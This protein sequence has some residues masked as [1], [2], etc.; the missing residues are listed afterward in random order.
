MQGLGT[1]SIFTKLKEK[2]KKKKEKTLAVLSF[3][4]INYDL[5]VDMNAMNATSEKLV[6]PNMT[7]Y[8]AKSKQALVWVAQGT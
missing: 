5:E 2:K 1:K 6:T 4:A 7:W 3:P 8:Y